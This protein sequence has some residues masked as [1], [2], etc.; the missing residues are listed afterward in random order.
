MTLSRGRPPSGD[1]CFEGL[2]VS[3]PAHPDLGY[4]IIMLQVLPFLLPAGK[5]GRS[6]ADYV[7]LFWVEKE[8]RGILEYPETREYSQ[9]F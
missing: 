5:F 3:S 2:F 9:R 8:D 7:L 4:L 6:T 1:L